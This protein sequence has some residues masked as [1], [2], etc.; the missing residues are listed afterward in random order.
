MN[1]LNN[2]ENKEI[3]KYY[4]EYWKK[5]KWNTKKLTNL[6]TPELNI[7][8][9]RKLAIKYAT[10]YLNINEDEFYKKISNERGYQKGTENVTNKYFEIFEALS[11]TDNEIKILKILKENIDYL[12]NKKINTQDQ[13]NK[14]IYSYRPKEETLKEELE[15]KLQIIETIK[16]ENN[17]INQEKINIEYENIKNCILEY[18]DKDIDK[19]D[20]CKEKNISNE[21]FEN[22]LKIMKKEN[23]PI[24]DLYIKKAFLINKKK[25]QELIKKIPE[26]IELLKEGN[27]KKFNLLEYYLM[28]NIPIKR[29]EE[30]CKEEIKNKNLDQIDYAKYISKFITKNKN[31]KEYTE[32]EI[33]TLLTNERNI[34]D[35]KTDEN[36]N[37]IEGTG[38]E[39]TLEEK[40]E[41][42]TFL[43]ENNVPI[44]RTT[45][46]LAIAN[47]NK[48]IPKEKEKVKCLK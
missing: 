17:W 1:K 21:T 27:N 3:C 44:T 42:I 40:E 34:I 26:I 36:G 18:I 2:D 39:L 25:E 35:F 45:F 9:I 16:F 41:I 12:E 33:N 37:F 29:F 28:T 6:A 5:A 15:Q 24:Y 32:K 46:N 48:Y 7:K 10:E 11:D 20:F 38:R 31:K 8:Q 4:Y 14:Y 23:K 22:Y 19:K 47:Y 13:L 30:I 43:K